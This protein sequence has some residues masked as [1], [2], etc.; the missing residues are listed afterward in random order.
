MLLALVLLAGSSPVSDGH[1]AS[2]AIEHPPS[3]PAARI[4]VTQFF[5]VRVRVITRAMF[6]LTP[7]VSFQ[8]FDN[9]VSANNWKIVRIH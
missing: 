4:R 6:G 5:A 1:N 8:R 2:D 3:K 9:E 7:N